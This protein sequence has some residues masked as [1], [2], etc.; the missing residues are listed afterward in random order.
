MKS[1]IEELRLRNVDAAALAKL[2]QVAEKKHLSR[3]EYI[4]RLIESAAFSSE[5]QRIEEK[6]EELLNATLL[7]IQRNTDELCRL[8]HLIVGIPPVSI[9]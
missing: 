3:N 8:T 1:K 9:S 2:A 6:Y 4:K 5:L 7:T